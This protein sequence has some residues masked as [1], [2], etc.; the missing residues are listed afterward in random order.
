[1]EMMK[2]NAQV[3]LQH[4]QK[5]KSVSRI[6]KEKG[7]ELKDVENIERPR[8]TSTR[9]L[10]TLKPLP[11]IDPKDKGKKKIKE[12]ESDTES[13]DINESE[14]KFKMLAHDEEIA[15]KET[16]DRKQKKKIEADR[17]LALR[18]QEEEREQFT[19]EEI[20]KLLHDIIAAQRRFLAEQ[21]AAAIRN[22]PPTRTQ[23]RSQMTTY[24][25]HVGTKKHLD[26]KNK[27]FEEIQALYE[28]VKRFDK[29][30]TVIGSNKDERKIKEI[31]EG[32][33]D[34]DNKKK[35]IKED[36]LTKVP[37]KQEVVE[38]GTKKRKGGHMKMLTRRRKRPQPDVDSDDEHIKCLKIVTF[39]EPIGTSGHSTISWSWLVQDQTVLGKDY[40]NLLIA[41][42]LLKTIWFINAPC[43]GNEALASPKANELTIPEQTATGKGKS[44]P[45]MAVAVKIW[46]QTIAKDV[47]GSKRSRSRLWTK[48]WIPSLQELKKNKP[49][50]HEVKQV[51]Q[52]CLGEDC[53]EIYI[54][55]LVPL[56][57]YLVTSDPASKSFS[58]DSTK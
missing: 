44:N 29:S 5:P 54:P 42:S 58:T 4:E 32:V 18:L 3:L 46:L 39:E 50:K 30:F 34:P 19:M 14:K 57:I 52:S 47:K 16:K 48:F 53:W 38:Q 12:D 56:V 13:E 45:F 17:L 21:R 8:P 9:S 35:V 31:N 37:A 33:S 51:Q 7:V 41:D 26:L 10:L 28:K 36:V 49:K 11:K 15:R 23:L 1:M 20:V 40:S 22:R 24:L 6:K 2:T 27:T 55:N 43:Y 25:K